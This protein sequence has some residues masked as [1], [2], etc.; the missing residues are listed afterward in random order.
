MYVSY[1]SKLCET[2]LNIITLIS[3]NKVLDNLF[4]INVH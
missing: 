1:T 3:Y 2:V 4:V